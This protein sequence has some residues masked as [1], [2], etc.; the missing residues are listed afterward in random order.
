MENLNSKKH[1]TFIKILA[2]LIFIVPLLFLGNCVR[3]CIFDPKTPEKIV[4]ENNHLDGSVKQ[5]RLYVKNNIRNSSSYESLDWSNL[6]F[7]DEKRV[8]LVRHKYRYKND[9]DQ[10]QIEEKLFTIDTLGNVIYELD[11]LN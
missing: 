9:F 3:G 4:I 10:I 7:N 6:K 1:P 5:V 8:Y 11:L 2:A